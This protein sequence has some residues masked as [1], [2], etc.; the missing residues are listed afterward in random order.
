M[1]PGYFPCGSLRIGHDS[2]L[3]RLFCTRELAWPKRN[4]DFALFPVGRPRSETPMEWLFVFGHIM[5]G[6]RLS[7]RQGDS[8]MTVNAGM[9]IKLRKY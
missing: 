2:D 4:L 5:F 8:T 1:P 3:G 9:F 7:R 6:R